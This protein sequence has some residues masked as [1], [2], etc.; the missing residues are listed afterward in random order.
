[1]NKID[2]LLENM[3][4]INPDALFPTDMKKAIIGIVERAGMQP[5]ILLDR[6]K[7]I[8]ILMKDGMSW[9][10]AE[11]YFEFNTIGAHMGDEGTPCFA[12]ILK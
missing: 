9:E 4:N 12:T 3:E 10:D 5:Q 8:K 7:C 11:E 2:E 6:E 1:M